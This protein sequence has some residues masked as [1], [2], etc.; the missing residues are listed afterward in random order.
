MTGSPD[1][2]RRMGM[3][4][5]TRSETRFTSS[6]VTLDSGPDFFA[7]LPGGSTSDEFSV[8]IFLQFEFLRCT[9]QY[10][11]YIWN[12]QKVECWWEDLGTEI[13]GFIFWGPRN[14][15]IARKRRGI[16]ATDGCG[17]LNNKGTK[18]IPANIPAN[19][20]IRATDAFSR[21]L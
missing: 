4:R 13:F 12:P 3:P 10:K 14:T 16:G 8:S 2:A 19:T 9:E 11:N 15:R 21:R 1:K 18:G 6:T 5:A 7:G 17:R 20:S